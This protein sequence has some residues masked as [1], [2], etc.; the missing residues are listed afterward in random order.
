MN[1]EAKLRHATLVWFEMVRRLISEAASG[2]G[3]SPELNLSLVE[4]YIDG[5]E[6]FEG[7]VQSHWA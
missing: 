1:A 5:V 7:L 3:L 2:S 6:L 4:R